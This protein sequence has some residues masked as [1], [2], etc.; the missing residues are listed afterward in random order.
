[1]KSMAGIKN[2]DVR[3]EVLSLLKK[4]S[5]GWRIHD[6]KDRFLDMNNGTSSQLL[7]LY[8]INGSLNLT[9]SVEILRKKS[10]DVQVLKVWDIL[11]L[12]EIPKLTKCLDA[13]FGNYTEEIMNRCKCKK[14][15][16]Y[17]CCLMIFLIGTKGLV[18]FY[19]ITF[20]PQEFRSSG[21][22]AS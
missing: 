17:A 20:M 16:G 15:E 4:L 18:W 19:S 14:L 2:I 21:V 7:K 11:P 5:S 3:K 8:K 13:L 12:S 10:K 1:M 6:H 22:M 9:W